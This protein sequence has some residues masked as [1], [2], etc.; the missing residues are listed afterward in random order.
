MILAEKI[1]LNDQKRLSLQ[2]TSVLFFSCVAAIVLLALLT[3]HPNDP[4]LFVHDTNAG[5]EN[6]AG[7]FGAFL[8][9]ILVGFLGYLSYIIP[10]GLLVL[11]F[12]LARKSS[13]NLKGVNLWLTLLGGVLA[14]LAG[15][16]LATLLWP[17][18]TMIYKAGGLLGLMVAKIF[19]YILGQF[20][21][22]LFL[23][24]GFFAGITLIGDIPWLKIVDYVGDKILDG[25]DY[26]FGDGSGDK[27]TEA[28]KDNGEKKP[29][30]M[31][32]IGAGAVGAA[33][34]AGSSLSFLKKKKA[35]EQ[36]KSSD[37]I[38]VATDKVDGDEKEAK[39]GLPEM[40]NKEVS[41]KNAADSGNTSKEKVSEAAIDKESKDKPIQKALTLPPVSLLNESPDGQSDYSSDGLDEH[42]EMS[43]KIISS[44]QDYGVHGVTVENAQPGPII[45]RFELQLPAGTK[46]SKIT[47]LSKDLAR[48]MGVMSVRIVEVI[49]GKTTI[50]IEVPNP[51]RDLV[52]IR[53]IVSSNEFKNAESP[54]TLVLGKSIGG[55]PVV[56]DL[57]KMPHLLVAGTTGSGKSVAVN[58][59]L[60][61]LL[62][63]SS[64]KDVRLILIDPKMLELSTYEGIPHLLTSVVTDMKDAAN[65]LRWCVGEME[66]RYS[67]MSHV[68]VRSIAGY[69]EKV[70]EAIKNGKPIMDPSYDPTKHVDIQ[71][72]ILEPLP[73]I[74]VV[75]DEF[76]DMVMV[77]GKKVEELIAR[78]A[79][80]ARASGIHLVLATQRP[81]VDVITGL[82]KANIPSRIA[83]QVSTKIDSRTILD[84]GGAEQLL[85]LGD[86]L[87]LPPGT[88]LPKRV[89]GAFVADQE[90]EDVVNYIKAQ[91]E[92]EYLA[93]V[94]K[95][96]GGAKGAIPGLEP[97][98]DREGDALYDEA[99][100]I[101]TE[102]R[103]ASISYLQ[104][105]LKIGYN[106]A[107][108]M[109]EEMETAGVV[110]AVQSNGTREVLAPEP[111]AN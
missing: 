43:E 74:V 5:V 6:K 81:S 92:P 109:I 10:A 102:S 110:S 85:G 36:G 35:D 44:L 78:L 95:D 111:V 72:K 22:T 17:E 89:H 29:S 68:K 24:G 51:S 56:A 16:G 73:Y 32:K 65:A 70:G 3:Y 45:T 107:A 27:A 104:R 96:T 21:A 38:P 11:G 9:D 61:S 19:V 7:R 25:F 18:S 58:A 1:D 26:I 93:D 101:V 57:T 100:V 71:P 84:Q 2:Q 91:G 106:R 64:P 33:A 62:Y 20:G 83:F 97:L 15:C 87:Y 28:K 63:K 14:L 98:A 82:I 4:G 67:V 13:V 46:V 34:V 31:A 50:G 41:E 40:L 8:A 39:L 54:L 86:M 59:M 105:R 30:L 79:Q 80:K 76:A 48:N 66:R 108:T 90:V 69:N 37:D 99:V 53:D 75:I 52:F 55:K 60:M 77:V 94:L 103:R 49:P 23:F 47:G 88:G 42:H 12:S